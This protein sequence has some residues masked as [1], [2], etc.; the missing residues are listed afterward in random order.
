MTPPRG[1]KCLVT[2][3][4]LCTKEIQRSIICWIC[5]PHF[6]TPEEMARKGAQ[7]HS[8]LL[9]KNA[10]T[11][12]QSSNETNLHSPTRSSSNYNVSRRQASGMWSQK[13]DASF[14]AL[15]PNMKLLDLGIGNLHLR[16]M[17]TTNRNR[18]VLFGISLHSLEKSS[19]DILAISSFDLIISERNYRHSD[20]PTACRLS[21]CTYPYELSSCLLDTLPLSYRHSCE[22]ASQRGARNIHNVQSWRKHRGE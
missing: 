16:G 11:R 6:I 18:L 20:I 17:L 8:W 3:F 13:T 1:K 4:I 7:L 10:M 19:R 22:S 12:A 14:R 5:H 15:N 21:P 9:G 2:I